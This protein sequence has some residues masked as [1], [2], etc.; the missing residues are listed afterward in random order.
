MNS[1]LYHR[2]IT[3]CMS[4]LILAC[5]MSFSP[6]AQTDKSTSSI[7]ERTWTSLSGSKVEGTFV[8]INGQTISL[9]T[10]AGKVIQ[11]DLF[12][13]SHDDRRVLEG[14]GHIPA[15]L[16]LRSW[17]SGSGKKLEATLVRMDGDLITLNNGHRDFQVQLASL[18]AADQTYVRELLNTKRKKLLELPCGNLKEGERVTLAVP[19]PD[20]IRQLIRDGAFGNTSL[21]RTVDI[22]IAVPENF[23][24]GK[25]HNI[26]IISAPGNGRSAESMNS[27]WKTGIARNWVVIGCSNSGGND[28]DALSRMATILSGLDVLHQA[29]TE[30]RRW[31]VAAGGNSGGAKMSGDIAVLLAKHGYDLIGIFKGGC[32]QQFIGTAITDYKPDKSRLL[33]TPV[34]LSSGLS[35]TV[36]T[37]RMF[38][39]VERQLKELGFKHV[40]LENYDGAHSVNQEQ[41]ATALDWFVEMNRATD[42]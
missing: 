15:E 13:L 1:T 6:L 26:L 19:V 38:A 16:H 11:I 41:I 23:D 3:W 42:D 32:N 14:A 34:Y 22:S 18:S 20:S 7:N 5:M 17:T 2:N 40:R 4:W 21:G 36:A 8:E 27:F 24:P 28:G 33:K 9:R 35:D 29:W 39:T 25:P 12:A 31:P 37:P 30:S 10:S